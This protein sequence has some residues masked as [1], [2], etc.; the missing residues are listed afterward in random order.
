MDYQQIA[1]DFLRALRGKRSQVAFCRRL[2][3][4]SNVVYTWESKRGF[5]T[6]AK[7]LQAAQRVGVD[8]EQAVT[9][10]YLYKKP[11][12]WLGKT[13]LA[14]RDGVA[15][16]LKDLKGNTSILD[17]AKYSGKSRF[18]IA[19]WLKGTT[20]PKLPDFFLLIESASLR[21]VD[22]VET[23]VSPAHV[24]AI[25]EQ[26]RSLEV[27][28]RLAYDAP[29][30]QAVLRV[31]ELDEAQR[32]THISSEWIA[33]HVGLDPDEVDRSLELLEQSGQIKRRDGRWEL[34]HVSALDTRKH[35][36]DARQ[37]RIW[38]GTVG[39]RRAEAGRAGFKYNLFNVSAKD[40]ER[41]R[42]LQTAYMSEMR[43]IISQSQPVER[44]VLATSQVVELG[45]AGL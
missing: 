19:R 22:F 41:L 10:F 26:W 29:W 3:Y 30:T 15:A 17:L 31:L 45:D 39:L 42:Q 44:V 8:L 24:P 5:P 13:D 43:A 1:A 38:W 7:A 37:L 28:R 36:D 20:E 16:L 6:A 12:A 2:G 4:R 21:L 18:A 25:R 40:L 27:A 23:F 14:S 11:P 34:R 9:R 35:P 33:K 32:Q